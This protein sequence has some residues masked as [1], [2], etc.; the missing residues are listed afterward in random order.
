M[1][2]IKLTSLA[3]KSLNYLDF[4]ELHIAPDLSYISGVTDYSVGLQDGEEVYVQSPY[5]TK[6]VSCKASAKRVRRQ[7][8]VFIEKVL[9]I[10]T[11]KA[12]VS[13]PV[14]YSGN[15]NTRYYVVR[16]ENIAFTGDTEY[17]NVEVEQKYIEYN[18]DISYFYKSKDGSVE[19]YLVDHIFYPASFGD[20]SLTIRTFVWIEDGMVDFDGEKY[21]ADMS[22]IVNNGTYMQ[23]SLR[24]DI[25]HA[26]LKGREAIPNTS[27][28]LIANDFE[29]P[30]IRD[31]EPSKW[32]DIIKFVV[33]KSDDSILELD[34]VT[35]GGYNH[36]AVFNDE[37]YQLDYIYS[38]DSRTYVGYGVM[39]DGK[40]YEYVPRYVNDEIYSMHKDIALESGYICNSVDNESVN[41]SDSITT[42]DYGSFMLVFSNSKYLM[43][44]AQL[45]AESIKPITTV[46]G[47][48]NEKDDEGNAYECVYYNGERYI[49][50]ENEYDTVSVGEKEY[51]IH[52]TDETLS[53][54]YYT[55][56]DG[57][58]V[59]IEISQGEKK[60]WPKN[61]L[62]FSDDDGE[63][64]NYGKLSGDSRYDITLNKSI[65]V[66]GVGYIMQDNYDEENGIHD[67]FVE[68]AENYKLSFSIDDVVGSNMYVCTPVINPNV[69]DEKE[70]DA[71]R[72][73]IVS[74]VVGNASNFIF[75]EHTFEFGIQPLDVE[76]YLVESLDAVKPFTASDAYN[77]VKQFKI[78]RPT[79]YIT[80]NLPLS[81][82]I[83][84]N[85]D[86]ETVI[87]ND[88]VDYAKENAISEVV[89]M[90][91]DIYYPVYESA[92]GTYNPIKEMRFNFHFRT[93][94]LDS[95]KTYEDDRESLSGTSELLV[96]ENYSKGYC[97]WF[98]TDYRFYTNIT[99]IG[100]DGI[101]DTHKSMKK[102]CQNTSDL[103]GLLGFSS[104]DIRY[105]AAKIAKS[106]MRLSFYSTN[107]PNTQMLLSTSTVFLDSNTA[108]KK[109]SNLSTPSGRW[110]ADIQ[111]LE[112]AGTA[113]RYTFTYEE[114]Q[115]TYYKYEE[116]KEQYTKFNYVMGKVI[117]PL[118]ETVQGYDI[119]KR[120]R[121]G[122]EIVIKDKYNSESSSEGYY[123]YMFKEYARALRKRRIYMR[124]DFN[125]AGIGKSIP[126]TILRRGIEDDGVGTPLYVFKQEDIK[127]LK[128]GIPMKDMYKQ[129]FIPIDV[130]YDK[131]S[132]KYVYMLPEQLRE[133]SELGVDNNIMEFNLFE[134][135]FANESL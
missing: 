77:A 119:A 86:R 60:A 108:S 84:D 5:T 39:Y 62:L 16:G 96:G 59:D 15:T 24:K 89:D 10:K 87:N 55:T 1:Q 129:L 37:S 27:I 7:G 49:F 127:E 43:L 14:Y 103:M 32:K 82:R 21:M 51:R 98:V 52:Y 69:T 115:H 47:V 11:I 135:K 133:N 12:H 78:V 131:D 19:G 74:K 18:G 76:N 72:R 22:L 126:M 88:F 34:S 56:D 111:K 104:N 112:D 2:H 83:G 92:Q 61:M 54:G 28:R 6:S 75:K 23:P 50:V 57:N 81:S 20:D 67:Y 30:L 13:L 44:G 26:R 8:K 102:S 90:E 64:V 3:A 33:N 123:L 36:Y 29:E 125:H 124:I 45:K 128:N 121:I 58:R 94:N 53:E 100:E 41:V 65:T 130:V 35:S 105:R 80:L 17:A 132:N 31:Y 40:F 99:N 68:I 79:T 113:K 114:L 9:P 66:N 73:D 38:G 116:Y 107:D 109:F 4:S 70:V 93:R 120:S 63:T 42:V 134:I 46:V 110:F 95:W 91:K 25:N 117:S 106:F 71:R 122:S 48:V 97:N 101:L 118:C 85:I